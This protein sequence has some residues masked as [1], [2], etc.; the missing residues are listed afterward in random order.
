[1]AVNVRTGLA[2]VVFVAC[3]VFPVE[4]ADAQEFGARA[5]FSFDPDQFYIGVHAESGPIVDELRF[6]PNVEAGFGDN[7]TVVALN[8]ELVYPFELRN[9]TRLYGGGGPSLLVISRD[10]PNND[11]DLEPGFNFLIG[12]W[13]SDRI[14]G[15]LK[16]GA[17]DSPVLKL[18]VGFTF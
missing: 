1:M 4:S 12:V 14:F 2:W 15:E 8:A 3:L 6:R 18:G 13:F 10:N 9:G 16:L 7:R 11:T 17:I 5:G